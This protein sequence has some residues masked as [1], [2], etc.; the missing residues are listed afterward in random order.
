MPQAASK[1]RTTKKNAKNL[2][3]I[4]ILEEYGRKFKPKS[5]D[6]RPEER[7]RMREKQ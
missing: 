3:V 1:D 4:G 2:M 7:T 5:H 6:Q